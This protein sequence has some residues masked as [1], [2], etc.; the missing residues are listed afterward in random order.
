MGGGLIVE[1]GPDKKLSNLLKTFEPCMSSGRLDTGKLS[2]QNSSVG[3]LSRSGSFNL[4][5]EVSRDDS[6]TSLGISGLTVEEPG[7]IHDHKD[8]TILD[9][10]SYLKVVSAFDQPRLTYSTSKKS[11]EKVSSPPTLLS[12]TQNKTAM[13]RNRYHLIHQRLMRNESFQAPAFS[14]SKRKPA[15]VHSGSSVAS[16]QQAYKITPISNLLGRSGSFHLLLGMLVHSAAGDL[17]LT[18]LSGSVV[19]DL[20]TTRPIPEDGAWYCPGMVVL[21]E[22]RYLED[23]SNNSNLGTAA[24]IGGQIKGS[25]VAE[26]MAGPPAERRSLTLGLS[27]DADKENLAASVGAGFGW[28]DFLGVG[29]E[30][31]LGAQMR[32]IQKRILRSPPQTV[33]LPVEHEDEEEQE[34][35]QVHLPRTK[36]AILAECTL[37][38]PRT[39]EGIRAILSSYANASND[40]V[41]YP[42]S[43]ILMGNFISAASMAGSTKGGGSVEYKEHFDGLASVMTEFPNLLATTTFVF[44]PGDNDPWASSFSAGGATV[45]PRQGVP[46]I[47]TSRIRRAFTAANAE[48]TRKEKNKD[49]GEAIWAS[50][51]ARLTMFGP[52]EELVLFR[53]DITGRFRRNAVSFSKLDDEDE[54]EARGGEGDSSPRAHAGAMDMVGDMTPDGRDRGL[55]AETDRDHGM[56][57]TTLDTMVHEATSHVPITSNNMNTSTSTSTT[58]SSTVSARKLIKTV[59]DQSHL[60]PFPH[61]IRPIF[62]DHAASL[63][64]Y[65]LPTALVLADADTPA[66]SI[67]YEGCHVMNP[68]RVVDEDGVGSRRGLARWVEYDAVARRGE[69]REVRF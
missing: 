3:S 40:E 47:F 8:T 29:S 59:L 46:D 68:G 28:V 69:L 30:K 20:S 35:V 36:V 7:D 10:R 37:D 31:A 67:S 57:A 45:L 16:P 26:T 9:P 42:L 39:L 51:P 14:T 52:V 6:Q 23:G 2:R 65:P 56:P 18:D 41:D 54:D 55:G 48:L 38:S 58:S 25:F 53:D 17:A 32:R 33:P 50:N 24:G 66:F 1:D 64:L 49:P 19:L 11:V 21:V 43:F 61:S 27:A 12:A 22:G 44:V 5:P 13:F 15:L 62:W 4:R 34:H 63:S 60:A